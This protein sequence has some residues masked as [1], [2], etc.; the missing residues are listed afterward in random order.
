MTAVVLD[1]SLGELGEVS[2]LEGLFGRADVKWPCPRVVRVDQLDGEVVG[3][4]EVSCIADASV[5]GCSAVYAKTDL[6]GDRGVVK[7]GIVTRQEVHP[8][9]Y[10]SI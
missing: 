2:N 4:C 7:F 10:I 6:P 8:E 5:P 3:G 9:I 1:H